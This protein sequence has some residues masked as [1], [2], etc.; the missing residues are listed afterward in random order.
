M[1][2]GIHPSAIAEGFR[3]ALQEATRLLQTELS[4]PISLNDR[5]TL[6]KS[7]STSLNSKVVSQYANQIAAI[8]VDAVLSVVDP[9]IP[10][11]NRLEG[12][13]NCPEGRRNCR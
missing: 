13:S 1:A 7:A 12:H 11:F 9:A 10:E 5:P 8:A 2:R 3:S 4:I 6:L